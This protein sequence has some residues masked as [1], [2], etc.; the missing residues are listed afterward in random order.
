M[1]RVAAEMNLS[2]T[3]FVRRIHDTDDF[4]MCKRFFYILA[5]FV[6][7]ASVLNL[8]R[9][10]KRLILGSIYLSSMQ[11]YVITVDQQRRRLFLLKA[12]I[13]VN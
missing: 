13:A 1:Q 2:E 9:P 10:T 6:L 12:E 11:V 5:A 4:A 3:A 8:S 7:S